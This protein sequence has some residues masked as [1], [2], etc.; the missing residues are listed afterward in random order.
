LLLLSLAAFLLEEAAED[1]VA[2]V[3]KVVAVNTAKVIGS[4]DLDW[5]KLAVAMFAHRTVTPSL[6]SSLAMSGRVE[7]TS[8]QIRTQVITKNKVLVS[9]GF[10]GIATLMMTTQAR[11]TSA[12]LLVET[13][14]RMQLEL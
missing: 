6:V 14:V 12:Q 1:K 13:L 7:T 2:R 9:T 11:T 8:I 4:K 10:G 3:V 5:L